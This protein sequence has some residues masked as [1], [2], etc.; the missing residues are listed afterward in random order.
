LSSKK[1]ELRQAGLEIR[2]KM[3]ESDIHKHSSKILEYLF[4]STIFYK[5]KNIMTY[6]SYPKEVQTD[7][8][9]SKAL[10]IG[11]NIVVPVCD[12]TNTNLIPSSI[13]SLSLLEE[14]YYGL[15]EPKKDAIKPINPESLDLIIV[16]GVVF[17]HKG[18]RIGH[19]KGYYDR[20]LENIPSSI[21]K[22][23]LA[24]K[25]QVKRESWDIGPYD[26]PMDGIITE[27]GW[28]YKNF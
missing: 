22:I 19:G 1:E 24:F 11:K 6:V 23:A 18:N 9:I 16:P 26:I 25:S 20:F 2:K 28:I 14:G 15:R 17:D 5:S 13:S 10:N 21:P 12:L 4:E 3:Q 27:E 8:L 7:D